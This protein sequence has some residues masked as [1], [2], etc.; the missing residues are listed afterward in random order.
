[1]FTRFMDMH[2]GGSIK[3]EP[4]EQIY[5]ELPRKEAIKYF[6]RR[7]DRDPYN[8]TCTCCGEDY[9]V[10]EDD[11]L[12]QASG[13]YRGCKYDQRTRK[14]IEE[15]RYSFKSFTPLEDYLEQES[16]LVIFGRI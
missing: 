11:S 2:S 7:F 3:I 13:Y 10:S 5:I 4:Y 12:Q 14:Y 1:M 16:V 9:S 6:E 8:I 15:S